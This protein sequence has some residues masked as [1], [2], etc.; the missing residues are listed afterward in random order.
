MSENERETLLGIFEKFN[1][2][3][4]HEDPTYPYARV[5]IYSNELWDVMLEAYRTGRADGREEARR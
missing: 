2:N 3:G 5:T 1:V 4:V